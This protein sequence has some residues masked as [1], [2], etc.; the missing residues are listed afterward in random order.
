[1]IPNNHLMS[2]NKDWDCD[3]RKVCDDQFSTDMSNICKQVYKNSRGCRQKVNNFHAEV[4]NSG[5]S[6]Y[7]GSGSNYRYTTKKNERD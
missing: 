3:D 7:E 5:H 6:Y 4:R 2:I 1:M